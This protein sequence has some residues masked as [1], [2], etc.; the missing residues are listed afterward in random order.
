MP[1]GAATKDSKP[2]SVNENLDKKSQKSGHEDLEMAVVNPDS[3]ASDTSF[4]NHRFTD[5]KPKGMDHGHIPDI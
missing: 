1:L 5:L 4:D 3:P 2:S